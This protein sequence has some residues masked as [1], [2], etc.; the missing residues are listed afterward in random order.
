MRTLSRWESLTGGIATRVAFTA[1]DGAQLRGHLFMPPPGV[2]E[3]AAG[4]PGVV[5]TDGSVQ[6]YEQLYYWAAE[7]LAQAGYEV[8]TYDVQGQGDSDLLP[9]TSNCGAGQVQTGNLLCQGVPYQ[10]SYN[11]F[12]GAED[13]LNWFDSS[14]N[15]GYSKL[16]TTRIA[17]AGHSLGAAAVSE[18]GQCDTRVRTVVAWDNLDPVRGCSG[19]T[20]P[21]QYRA[22]SVPRVPALGLTNDYLFNPQPMSSPPEPHSKDAGYQQVAKAGIDSMEVAFR[23][24]THL[25]YTY[26]PLVLPASELA[27][28]FA[29]YYTLAWLDQYDRGDPTGFTRL[30]A[31]RFDSS[32]D[33]YS[34][35]AGTYSASQA[36]GSPTDPFAGNVPYV[37]AG[38]CLI[39]FAECGLLIGFFLP[40][41]SL[42]FTAGLFV[43]GGLIDTPIWL[44]CL[45][46][47]VCAVAGNVAG[48]YLGYKA[49]PALFD[50][51]HMGCREP[52]YT[53]PCTISTRVR[54]VA[55]SAGFGA[56]AGFSSRQRCHRYPWRP[57]D[58]HRACD[59]PSP[60]LG[61]R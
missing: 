9:S 46:V 34:I 1:L 20:I 45:L 51:A 16:D 31:T 29:F 58:R 3:P 44:V 55:A 33:R 24:A 11:F 43:A 2:G 12:Q 39:I 37:I 13:A 15:P 19:E 38:L 48:Y 57:R 60:W 50:R 40:G 36:L 14:A 6:G 17:I 4:Y 49:G 25:T 52:V 61:D 8:M 41:D 10:Q 56:I 28:R 26:V 27:E 53:T 54:G 22:T 47:T 7:G 35:G 18:V 5:I 42:L 21:A 30:T 59:C 23:G 32:S